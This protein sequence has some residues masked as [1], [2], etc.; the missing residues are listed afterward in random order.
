MFFPFCSGD[1][2]PLL[3]LLLKYNC[4]T[5]LSFCCTTAWLSRKYTY[6]CSLLSLP[7]TP[8]STA[9]GCHKVLGWAP[10]LGS[11]FPLAV[12]FTWGSVHL[13]CSSLTSSHS[14]RPPHPQSILY[15]CLSTAACKQAHQSLSSRFHIYALT[16]IFLFL[17]YFTLY[18]RL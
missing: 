18:D 13:Q 6:T 9:L 8:H 7:H 3:F 14:L 16:Y 15:I 2:S 1:L 17:T 4:F 12:Y 10:G 5:M 11:S